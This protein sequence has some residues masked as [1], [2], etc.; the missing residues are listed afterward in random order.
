MLFP[1]RESSIWVKMTEKAIVFRNNALGEARQFFEQNPQAITEQFHLKVKEIRE[2]GR[3]EDALEVCRQLQRE[4]LAT[5]RLA[6]MFCDQQS[7]LPEKWQDNPDIARTV[8]SMMSIF[9][10]GYLEAAI[11]HLKGQNWSEDA[12]SIKTARVRIKYL[13]AFFGKLQETQ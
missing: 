6:A 10:K 11:I 1:E 12:V 9:E 7:F 5:T 8:L 2:S 3:G 4:P 13:D